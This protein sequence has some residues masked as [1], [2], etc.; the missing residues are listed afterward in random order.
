MSRRLLGV[1]TSASRIVLAGTV[2]LAAQGV[3]F[4]SRS[5]SSPVTAALVGTNVTPPRRPRMPLGRAGCCGMGTI[6]TPRE[7]GQR[8]PDREVAAGYSTAADLVHSS[9][10]RRCSPLLK[11]TVAVTLV[12]GR[13]P[14]RVVVFEGKRG[15]GIQQIGD[16]E[17]IA[18]EVEYR[19]VGLEINQTELQHGEHPQSRL[20]RAAYADPG[21]LHRLAG[22]SGAAVA[23]HSRCCGVDARVSAF[24]SKG[25]RPQGQS[26]RSLTPDLAG[27]RCQTSFSICWL[28]R[29]VGV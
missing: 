15:F 2:D 28:T 22:P 20:P 16:T 9:S 10:E 14:S 23:I 26:R 7:A 18:V 24:W 4:Q 27:F 11:V 29:S 17:E 25:R 19:I 3:G 6:T 21:Q 8:V 12:A 5:T 13:S 1:R